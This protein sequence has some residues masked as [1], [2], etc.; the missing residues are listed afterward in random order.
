MRQRGRASAAA[1]VDVNVTGKPARQEPPSNLS[2][3][4]RAIHRT[5]GILCPYTFREKRSAPAS[6]LHSGHAA[7][8]P[9]GHW[10]G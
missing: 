8:S 7:G 10:D 2:D 4:E 1:L 9:G 3:D 6:Q 5:G